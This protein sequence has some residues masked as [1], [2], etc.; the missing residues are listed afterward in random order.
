MGD[1]K[2]V[3]SAG[4]AGSIAHRLFEDGWCRLLGGMAPKAAMH[5][6][7]AA[8]VRAVRLG[9]LD[10]ATLTGLGL[11]EAATATVLQ[12]GFDA[13][14]DA[15]PATLAD[16]LD[17]I[18]PAPDLS[19]SLPEFVV[20]LG[21]QPRAGATCPGRA[22]LVLEPAENHAEHCQM[23]AAYGVLLSPCFDADPVV[24][25]LAGIAHHLH[26]A[27][28]PD[29]GF[30]GEM[31]LGEQLG[32]VVERTSARAL[33]ELPSELAGVIA[34]ARRILPDADSPE[35]RA[36]HAADTLDRVWQIGHYLRAGSTS[37]EAVL[38]EMQL[39]HEGLVKPF[40]DAVL[41]AAGL[42][43]AGWGAAGLVA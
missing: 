13:V 20:R 21:A 25:W 7:V 5:G 26:N 30:T 9:D 42:G 2:R 27:Y 12:G 31:L 18:A 10:G 29:S 37:L 15:L 39:V 6:N 23:T 1:L 38:A 40:Q 33:A 8:M 35:G 11:D 17:L 22:R 36:F 16:Q 3:Y 28:L 14:R 19:R 43:T 4:R 32:P 41:A 34:Q 24:V